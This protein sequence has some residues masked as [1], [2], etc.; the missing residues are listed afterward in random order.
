MNL[1]NSS[2]VLTVTQLTQAIK[3]C[4]ESTFPFIH[5]QGE[6]SNFKLQSS[7]H[8][9]FSLKDAYAQIPAVMFKGQ[10]SF[11]KVIPK[12]GDQ[13]IVKAEISLYAPRGNYQLIIK[14]LFY[15]GVGELLQRLET[16][17]IKLHQKGWF[18]AIHKKALPKFPR[19]IG[20]I[21]SPTGSVIQDILH[22]LTRRFSNFHLILNPVKVQG[23]GSAQEI[24][25]AIKQ[26]NDYQLADVIIIARGGGS[27]EDL[28]SF[29]E[30]I[31]AEAIFQSDLPIISAVG[32][33]TDHCIADYVADIR[34]PTPS[35]AA[36]IVIAE[37]EHQ[38]DL[39]KNLRKRMQ[40]TIYQ[41]IQQNHYRLER[42]KKH[43]LLCRPHLMLEKRMQ[44]LDELKSTLEEQI[45]KFIF[46]KKYQL[47]SYTNQSSNL[48]PINQ[49][50]Y[51]KQNL[52]NIKKSL[53]QIIDQILINKRKQ[54]NNQIR[55]L[56]CFSIP[57]PLL[58]QKLSHLKDLLKAIDP[59]NVLL[60]GYS[61]LFAEKELS[62]IN[63]IDKLKKGQ[64]GQLLLSDGKVLIT[65]NE[66]ISFKQH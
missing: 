51:F 46:L 47:Q 52:D 7:G 13:V 23:E 11:L 32:H 64:K 63:S 10:A 65:I 42:F 34:A 1:T 33:E 36:E 5:L 28:W 43:P 56:N 61:I 4:L 40:Q 26:M 3:N 16:L 45:K 15:V 37:K 24:A 53:N 31:V 58:K 12:N 20:V 39:L 29:N 38:I 41:L 22:V 25:L 60:K 59:K 35:A 50:N 2:S 54:I 66:I 19:C 48:K 14:E 6:I 49:I 21:T 55:C 8:L 18:K 30:E 17:K 9:Y 62:V 27:I 57:N 44:Q